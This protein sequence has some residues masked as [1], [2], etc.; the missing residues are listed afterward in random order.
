VHAK[1]FPGDP[2]GFDKSLSQEENLESF[3]A[4]L[5]RTLRGRSLKVALKIFWTE[6]TFDSIGQPMVPDPLDLSTVAFTYDYYWWH[7]KSADTEGDPYGSLDGL[8]TLFGDM[9]SACE[10]LAGNAKA[11]CESRAAQRWVRP[12]PL[13]GAPVY[14]FPLWKFNIPEL[15]EKADADQLMG[16]SSDLTQEPPLLTQIKAL[17]DLLS[18]LEGATEQL[19]PNGSK[20]LFEGE[21][22]RLV[23]QMHFN[24]LV[25]L[26]GYGADEL[27]LRA[28]ARATHWW[29]TGQEPTPDW[30]K[31]QATQ[32]RVD[33]KAYLERT[34]GK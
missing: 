19:I 27:C 14:S 7:R 22:G 11:F 1:R 13:I 17:A 34:S 21:Y 5:Q 8:R 9:R 15:W 32:A 4:F 3:R 23:G 2:I 12:R 20:H 28:I 24:C 16:P 29:V 33:F 10:Q 6:R 26:H 31:R 25:A 18:A 30:G